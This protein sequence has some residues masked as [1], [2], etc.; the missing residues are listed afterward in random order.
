MSAKKKCKTHM[1]FE[2]KLGEL[3]DFEKSK[4]KLKPK[5]IIK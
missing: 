5:K 1:K 3:I 4:K 2:S